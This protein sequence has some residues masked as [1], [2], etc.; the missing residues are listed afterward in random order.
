MVGANDRPGS[1]ADAVLRNLELAGFDGP[2]WGVNPKREQ[3]HGR[4]CVPSVGDLPE[5]V[6]AV[7]IAIPASDVPAAVAQAR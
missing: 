3:V 7:V 4:E 2:V 6:D 1:Y 5:P